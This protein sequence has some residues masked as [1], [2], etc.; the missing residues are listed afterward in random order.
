MIESSVAVSSFW[1]KSSLSGNGGCVEVRRTDSGVQLRDSKNAAG[2]VLDFTD[3]EWLAFIGGVRLGEFEIG[4]PES[5]S[6]I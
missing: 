2:P 4:H 1:K 5:P 6:P 3:R